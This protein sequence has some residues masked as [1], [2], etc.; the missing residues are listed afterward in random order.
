MTSPAWFLTTM[1]G[2]GSSGPRFCEEFIYYFT[3]GFD[4]GRVARRNHSMRIAN[5][6]IR[7]SQ[8]EE[9]ARHQPIC[10]MAWRR[11]GMADC[12]HLVG[13]RLSPAIRDDVPNPMDAN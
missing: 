8:Y 9:I 2:F 6:L 7:V 10:A 1:V 3:R 5:L 12:L 4:G 11:S 13:K